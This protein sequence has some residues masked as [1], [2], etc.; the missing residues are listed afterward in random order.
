MI[1]EVTAPRRG[2]RALGELAAI[3]HSLLYPLEGFAEPRGFGPLTGEDVATAAGRPAFRRPINRLAAA[4]LRLAEAAPAPAVVVR[5]SHDGATR[6]ATRLLLDRR[7]AVR[8]AAMLA[9]AVAASRHLLKATLKADRDRAVAVFGADALRVATREAPVLY[10]RIAALD[11]GEA[12]AA[13]LAP[14]REP[15]AAAAVAV[16]GGIG[17]L[18]RFA[19]TVDPAL[20]RLFDIRFSRT[21]RPGA[22]VAAPVAAQFARL[23]QQ[24]NPSWSVPTD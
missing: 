16:D 18:S 13:A 12:I 17:L 6:V 2:E 20:G 8:A 24:G 5:A 23:L 19:R 10:G 7:E 14:G 4:E 9:A 1:P 11:D 21:D 15:A 22:A 3:A